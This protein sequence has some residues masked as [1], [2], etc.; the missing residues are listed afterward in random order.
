MLAGVTKANLAD[1]AKF[2]QDSYKQLKPD[3]IA[4]NIRSWDDRRVA[5]IANKGG[6]IN[7]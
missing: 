2:A 7:Y 3:T 5:L 1:F 6:P 4:N